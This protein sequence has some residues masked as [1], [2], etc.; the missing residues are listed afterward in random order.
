MRH[1]AF[2]LMRL[3]FFGCLQDDTDT[4]EMVVDCVSTATARSLIQR[5]EDLE[6]TL[7]LGLNEWD[8]STTIQS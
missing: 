5:F 3:S 6:E 1:H 8:T 2:H 4:A 7:D